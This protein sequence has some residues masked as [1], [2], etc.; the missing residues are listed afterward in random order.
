MVSCSHGLEQ[1]IMQVGVSD[2]ESYSSGCRKQ[3]VRKIQKEPENIMYK[4]MDPVI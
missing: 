4:D 1:N 3:S 2:L